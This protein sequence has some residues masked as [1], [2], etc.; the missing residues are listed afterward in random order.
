ME[1]TDIPVSE[2][3]YKAA[4]AFD[5]LVDGEGFLLAEMIEGWYERGGIED[6]RKRW[7]A[8][9]DYLKEREFSGPEARIV[10]IP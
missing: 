1:E 4:A 6:K 10:I 5:E 7:R 2:D 8:I 3:V 9:G